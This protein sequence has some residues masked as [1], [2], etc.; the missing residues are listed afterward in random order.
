M[1]L[2]APCGLLLPSANLPSANLLSANV[3]SAN[4]LSAN[5]P[6]VQLDVEDDDDA[7]NRV[8][9]QGFGAWWAVRKRGGLGKACVECAVQGRRGAWW[10]GSGMCKIAGAWASK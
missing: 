4:L 8:D 3:P 5:V 7:D 10:F 2:R 6:S 9:P 1:R